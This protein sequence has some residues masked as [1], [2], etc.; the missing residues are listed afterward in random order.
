MFVGLPTVVADTA[1][2]RFNGEPKFDEGNALGYFIWR[3]GNS[4]RVRWT[5][6]G[7]QHR[8]SGRI[9]LEGGEITA[10]KRIDVDTERRVIR[11][12]RAGRVVRG[13]R[14]RVVGVT[15]GRAPVV[16]SR[17]EDVIEQESEQMIRFATRTDDDEDGVNFEVSAGTAA[18]RFALEIDGVPRPAEVEVGRDNFKPNEHPVVV[19][20]R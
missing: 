9:T 2:V 5:T 4:W 14:G 8:F 20:L 10:M 1:P 3:D 7:A 12:G 15:G 19:R 13:P 11:E 6:F 16:A 17:E 18:V